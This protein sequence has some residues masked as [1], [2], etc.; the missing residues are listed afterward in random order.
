MYLSFCIYLH[1]LSN[2]YI[3]CYPR[4]VVIVSFRFSLT[5]LCFALTQSRARVCYASALTAGY[6]QSVSCQMFARCSFCKF[7]TFPKTEKPWKSSPIHHNTIFDIYV[8]SEQILI[9]ALI[10][11]LQP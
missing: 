1:E 9:L 11:C 6:N 4:Y 2:I 7:H 5:N 10:G 8:T 3:L